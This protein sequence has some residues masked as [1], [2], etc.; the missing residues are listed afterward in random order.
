MNYEL[1][2]SRIGA[3]AGTTRAPLRGEDFQTVLQAFRKQLDAMLGRNLAFDKGNAAI[4]AEAPGARCVKVSKENTNEKILT[5]RILSEEAVKGSDGWTWVGIL[6]STKMKVSIQSPD[7]RRHM[8]WILR[9]RCSVTACA[10]HESKRQSKIWITFEGVPA[11]VDPLNRPSEQNVADFVALTDR[12]EKA[13]M[14]F[15]HEAYGA[16]LKR[17]RPEVSLRN[18][19]LS[20]PRIRVRMTDTTDPHVSALLDVMYSGARTV[21]EIREGGTPTLMR[22]QMG[23]HEFEKLLRQIGGHNVSHPQ[24]QTADGPMGPKGAVYRTV[25][26]KTRD[27]IVIGVGIQVGTVKGQEDLPPEKRVLDMK[28]GYIRAASAVRPISANVAQ[29]EAIRL[30]RRLGLS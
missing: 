28:E 19:R 1:T 3:L 13:S 17:T 23:L 20:K 12:M 21:A 15:F 8:D 25:D 30:E 5:Y 14:E 11:N 18:F 4:I 29:V 7:A 9:A 26:R 2:I 16:A 10:L 24:L 27:T 6:P 22:A